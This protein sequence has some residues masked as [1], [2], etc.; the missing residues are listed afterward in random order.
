[1]T[2]MD[3]SVLECGGETPNYQGSGYD[4]SK[5][6]ATDLADLW[7]ATTTLIEV[8]GGIASQPRFAGL[9]S[10]TQP[11]GYVLDKIL[12]SLGDLQFDVYQRLENDETDITKCQDAK[13]RVLIRHAIIYDEPLPEVTALAARLTAQINR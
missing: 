10:G 6:K 8:V 7:D 9:N 2:N 1:M 4:L 12:E 5:L 13:A 3:T 11:A